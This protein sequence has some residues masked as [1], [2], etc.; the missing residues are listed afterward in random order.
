MPVTA[1]NFNY[2]GPV[3]GLLFV[4]LVGDWFARGRRR[5][6]GPLKLLM[7]VSQREEREVRASR[8]S[9]GRGDI[10]RRTR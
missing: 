6:E 5:Y 3:F 10:S 2:A 7:E 8:S 1:R 9:V 4:F